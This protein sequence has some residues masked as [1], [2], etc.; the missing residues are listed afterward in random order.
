MQTQASMR[1]ILLRFYSLQS[2]LLSH[3][4][5]FFLNKVIFLQEFVL[6]GSWLFL[7]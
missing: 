6:L 7:I 3:L 1:D 4:Y 5:F 2:L